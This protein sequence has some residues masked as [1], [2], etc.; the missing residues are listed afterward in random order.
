[1]LAGIAT[2]HLPLAEFHVI[3]MAIPWYLPLIVLA[4][5]GLA[6]WITI[7]LVHRKQSR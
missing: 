7:R 6:V 1:M 3:E 2:A 4:V 5:A